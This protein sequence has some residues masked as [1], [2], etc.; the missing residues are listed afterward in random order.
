[1]LIDPTLARATLAALRDIAGARMHFDD[2]LATV[3]RSRAS[4]ERAA[5]TQY[6]QLL[7]LLGTL[8]ADAIGIALQSGYE[9][10][11]ELAKAIPSVERA[12]IIRDPGIRLANPHLVAQ[13]AEQEAEVATAAM[14]NARLPE[15]EWLRL[16]P[17][18]PVRARGLLRHRKD[19]G[20][21]TDA[22]LARLG[23]GD[24]VLTGPDELD[25]TALPPARAVPQDIPATQ[26]EPELHSQPQTELS[27]EEKEDQ[28]AIGAIVRRIEA[29]RRARESMAPAS[30][31]DA[32]V[33]PLDE[34]H[35]AVVRTLPRAFDFETDAKGHIAWADPSVA[36]MAVGLAL[37]SSDDYSPAR[38]DRSA[39]RAMRRHLPLTGGTLTIEGSPTISG[40]WR[41]DAA[42]RFSVPEGNFTG[43]CGRLRRRPP[44]PM[45][46]QGNEAAL[47]MRELLHELRTPVNAIQGFSEVIQQQVFGPAPHEYRA[48]A[49]SIAGDAA[50]I[51]AGFDELDRL[52]KLES[53]T[54]ELEPGRHDFGAALRSIATQLK[55]FLEAR[56]GSIALR[57]DDQ[58]ILV[59]M[60]KIEADRMAWRLLATLCGAMTAGEQLDIH[61]LREGD[62][63]VF[64][65]EL[66]VTLAD[67]D[68]IFSAAPRG[69]GQAITAGLFG[70]GFAFRL[71]RAEAKAAGGGAAREGDTLQVWFPLLTGD[72]CN[73]SDGCNAPGGKE[74]NAAR[75]GPAGA[76][77][78]SDA[79][80]NGYSR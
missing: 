37:I 1:M 12:A 11:E 58:A 3:L 41:I 33:L 78:P 4:G 2:R 50:R 31:P 20:A 64:A 61:V 55:P 34:H 6:R 68:D 65:F 17:S 32:P 22:L 28:E 39:E 47:R 59:P 67:R 49:A 45:H 24:L 26:P 35:E 25:E 46:P 30:G 69:T 75:S 63:V 14:A 43:Y 76:E 62:R 8:P 21:E 40:L 13:L 56:S 54:L 51:L 18:L 23:I 44:P 70:S 80:D 66:P 77:T 79:F 19:L 73:H 10:L 36:P 60:A 7:D 42:P 38:L 15:E 57:G 71:A 53:D 29:F 74:S 9:R 27:V 5:R 48:L 72:G 52:T 16:I